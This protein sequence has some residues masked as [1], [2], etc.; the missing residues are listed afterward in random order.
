[1]HNRDIPLWLREAALESAMQENSQV[2]RLHSYIQRDKLFISFF[3]IADWYKGEWN[4]Y[5]I[6]PVEVLK[7]IGLEDIH[8]SSASEADWVLVN[9]QIYLETLFHKNLDPDILF[10]LIGNEQ[11]TKELVEKYNPDSIEQYKE[12]EFS[13]SY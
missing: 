5:S 7:R 8:F 9:G 6:L 10:A 4:F 3:F 1:M 12:L 11:L 2:N 13:W